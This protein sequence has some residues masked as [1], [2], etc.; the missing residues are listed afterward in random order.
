MS[1]TFWGKVLRI[2]PH[3]ELALLG[4]LLLLAHAIT[5]AKTASRSIATSRLAGQDKDIGERGVTSDQSGSLSSPIQSGVNYRYTPWDG[6]LVMQILPLFEPSTAGSIPSYSYACAGACSIR[7]TINHPRGMNLAKLPGIPLNRASGWFI[8]RS[9]ESDFRTAL[10]PSV[11][12]NISV[13][14]WKSID[15]RSLQIR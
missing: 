7:E 5:P 1:Q 6:S 10:R 4:K 14:N 12:I 15:H 2:T 13:R 8:S 3:G 11:R 9:L